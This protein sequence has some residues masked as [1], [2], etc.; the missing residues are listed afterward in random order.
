MGD[1]N[2]NKIDEFGQVVK[3]EGTANFCSNCGT[4]LPLGTKFCP[5]CGCQR[6]LYQWAHGIFLPV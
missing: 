1:I 4:R 5:G 6:L 3:S 2:I